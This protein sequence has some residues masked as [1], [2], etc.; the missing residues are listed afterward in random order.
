MKQLLTVL[1]FLALPV[2]AQDHD[3]HQHG[4]E[5]QVVDAA[6]E[7]AAEPTMVMPM[8]SDMLRSMHGDTLNYLVL[9]ERFEWLPDQA[10]QQWSAQGWY[11]SDLKKLWVKTEGHYDTDADSLEKAE[12][13]LLY[14]RAV[15][16]YWDLQAGL[17]ADSGH[18]PSRTYAAVGLQG[19]APYWF[20]VN[21]AAFL[22]DQGKVSARL[23]A[24]YEL[25][26]TQRLILQPRAELNYSAS[27]D[28]TVDL[29]QGF[30]E[31]VAGLRLRY[32]V[33]REFAPYLGVEW[34]R[35]YGETATLLERQGLD[36]HETSWVAGLRFWY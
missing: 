22:S 20:E 19:L 11:G 35:A 14:S 18:G 15:A 5:M 6:D 4:G 33:R 1:A 27:S 26:L 9:G 23:E 17:R 2:Q 28:F 34:G 24:E 3:A 31:V 36:V 30:N 8:A 13:Q 32:E 25:R 16:P 10:V 7:N 12:L 21:M 29:G